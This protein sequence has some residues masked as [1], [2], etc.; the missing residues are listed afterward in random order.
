MAAPSDNASSAR[1]PSQLLQIPNPYT[2]T[3]RN[4]DFDVEYDTFATV[5]PEFVINLLH[6]FKHLIHQQDPKKTNPTQNSSNY[7]DVVITVVD[8]EEEEAVAVL[9]QQRECGWQGRAAGKPMIGDL[10]AI[11][12]GTGPSRDD[13]APAVKNCRN[14]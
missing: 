8:E 6:M 1:S 9:L 4:P 10:M 2:Y 3:V 5:L 12:M 13:L 11:P 14:C 7:N